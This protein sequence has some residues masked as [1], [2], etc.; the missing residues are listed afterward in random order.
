MAPGPVNQP[1]DMPQP[2]RVIIAGDHGK[3][4]WHF[5]ILVIWQ[6]GHSGISSNL[7]EFGMSREKREKARKRHGKGMEK[8]WKRHG[9]V[10]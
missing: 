6:F 8:A 5:G 1:N 9:K 3:A 10:S 7:S 2:H 4:F